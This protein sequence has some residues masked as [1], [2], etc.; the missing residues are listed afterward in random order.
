MTTDDS[1]MIISTNFARTL[2]AASVAVAVSMGLASCRAESETYSVGPNVP[3]GDEFSL[4]KDCPAFVRVP[5]PPSALRPIRFVAATELTWNQYLAA[6]D[7]GAC[8]IPNPNSGWRPGGEN[9]LLP[10]LDDYR[11]D[12]PI[13]ELGPNEIKCYME[14]LQKRSGYTVSLP[15]VQEWEWFARSG[16]SSHYPW[17][18]DYD[19]S[20]EALEIQHVQKD[21]LQPSQTIGNKLKYRQYIR[22]VKVASFPPNKWGLYDIM[23][24]L[25][26]VT[27]STM[28]GAELYS[29]NP[30]DPVARWMKDKEIVLIKGDE[31]SFSKKIHRDISVTGHVP[32]LSGRYGMPLGV[33]LILIDQPR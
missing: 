24:N 29:H 9:D 28:S 5:N 8:E 10:N 3:I 15:T 19:S 11:V 4:C 26:E 21:I 32:I 27:S 30:N 25:S 23:G 22:G 12:W 6:Y 14:W 13:S 7:A 20:Q 17:G 33:R 16:G 31:I 2:I 1:A 18:N